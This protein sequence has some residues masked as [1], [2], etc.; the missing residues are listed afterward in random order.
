MKIQKKQ[1]ISLEKEDNKSLMVSDLCLE[2]K[3]SQFQSGCN[4]YVISLMVVMTMKYL[5]RKTH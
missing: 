2:N 4:L 3:G 5:K 1:Y